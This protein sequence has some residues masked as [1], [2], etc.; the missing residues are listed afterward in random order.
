MKWTKDFQ[1]D[2]QEE[3]QPNAQDLPE[4]DFAVYDL[5]SLGIPEKL[6]VE[7]Y[8]SLMNELASRVSSVVVQMFQGGE[9]DFHYHNGKRGAK[10]FFSRQKESRAP[11]AISRLHCQKD[12]NQTA[13]YLIQ[14]HR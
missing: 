12:R 8:C 2:F 6:K 3:S 9:D 4:T 1:G 11:G 10:G 14:I 7:L 5:N 13:N